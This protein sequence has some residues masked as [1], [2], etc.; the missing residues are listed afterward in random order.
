MM[1]LTVHYRKKNRNLKKTD[2]VNAQKH[3][4]RMNNIY[5]NPDIVLDQSQFNVHFKTSSRSYEE[6]FNQLK[7]DCKLF[8][9]VD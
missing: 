3:N 6:M 8:L 5:V 9:L 7:E 1:V 2:V 4:E